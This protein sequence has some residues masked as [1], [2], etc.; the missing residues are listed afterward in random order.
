M[1]PVVAATKRVTRPY[2]ITDHAFRFCSVACESALPF[3]F[4]LFSTELSTNAE[5]FSYFYLFLLCFLLAATI[6]LSAAADYVSA[7]GTILAQH[8]LLSCHSGAPSPRFHTALST[9]TMGIF[10]TPRLVALSVQTV[11]SFLS[12][13]Y[14]GGIAGVV[15][16]SVFC[17]TLPVLSYCTT[18]ALK[19]R[20][21]AAAAASSRNAALVALLRVLPAVR[22]TGFETESADRVGDAADRELHAYTKGNVFLALQSLSIAA[23]LPLTWAVLTAVLAG[24]NSDVPQ[25]LL[26]LPSVLGAEATA[27]C[28]RTVLS[29]IVGLRMA[30]LALP[31]LPRVDKE[32]AADLS[33]A[34]HDALRFPLRV[35]EGAGV[36]ILGGVNFASAAIPA[37][38]FSP[39]TQRAPSTPCL[40]SVRFELPPGATAVVVAGTEAERATFVAVVSGMGRPIV[41]SSD[42]AAVADLFASATQHGDRSGNPADPA[43]L[44]RG[45]QA[46]EAG[47]V[48]GGRL[49]CSSF[50]VPNADVA[51]AIC[52]AHPSLT[53]RD[54]CA[55]DPRFAEVCVAASADAVLDAPAEPGRLP[56]LRSSQLAAVSLAR[57]IYPSASVY[58]VEVG[59][60]A[61]NLAAVRAA[62]PREAVLILAPTIDEAGKLAACPDVSHRIRIRGGRVAFETPGRDGDAALLPRSASF[63]SSSS[64]PSHSRATVSGATASALSL[65]V[66]QFPR[67]EVKRV[68]QVPPPLCPPAI[69]GVAPRTPSS[70]PGTVA[71]LVAPARSG[72]LVIA[73]LTVLGAAAAAMAEAIGIALVTPPDATHAIRYA[74]L[75]LTFAV[76]SI[77]ASLLRAMLL[78]PTAAKCAATLHNTALAAVLEAQPSHCSPRHRPGVVAAFTA[79]LPHVAFALPS[80]LLSAAAA[81]ARLLVLFLILGFVCWPAAA[82]LLILVIILAPAFGKFIDSRQALERFATSQPCVGHLRAVSSLASLDAWALIVSGILGTA[83]LSATLTCQRFDPPHVESFVFLLSYAPVLAIAFPRALYALLHALASSDLAVVS[84]LFQLS[85]LPPE[86]DLHGSAQMHRAASAGQLVLSHFEDA[87]LYIPS[88]TIP[89][90]SHGAIVGSARATTIL[91]H[92]LLRFSSAFSGSVLLDGVSIASMPRHSLRRMLVA[93][94]AAQPPVLPGISLREALDPAGVQRDPWLDDCLLRAGLR[95]Y[96]LASSTRLIL[97]QATAGQMRR[98]ALAA[99]LARDPAVLLVE[100]AACDEADF[101]ALLR[102]CTCTVLVLCDS[103]SSLLARELGTIITLPDAA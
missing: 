43:G 24:Q 79:A 15:G 73:T 93:L 98:I 9:L 54:V 91:Q 8:L 2:I 27:I 101:A 33:A 48:V 44:A 76:V 12:I 37:A 42:H 60:S 86:S 75:C 78:P 61:E 92:G 11:V 20:R 18:K 32:L 29:A 39:D 19:H 31:D 68:S 64:A 14:F 49:S 38:L 53:A 23:A 58:V 87:G 40:R 3:A 21:H 45:Y 36:K 80:S 97:G 1:N 84:P 55:L 41:D 51:T 71:R 70:P 10:H 4:Y 52:G 17:V 103:E 30:L 66:A 16:V 6:A 74:S 67:F 83:V 85:M 28:V 35:E 22:A 90:G 62:L 26:T 59:V 94:V 102:Q 95:Q 69:S 96:S 81:A 50:L 47:L 99:A 5:S 56:R 72:A 65:H 7:Q 89:A 34:P 63:L 88:L 100:S 46:E 57:C 25:L 77:S 13:Y 82:L